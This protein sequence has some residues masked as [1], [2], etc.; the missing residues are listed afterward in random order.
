VPKDDLD[1]AKKCDL[2]PYPI[3]HRTDAY[4]NES[5]KFYIWSGGAARKKYENLADYLVD[6]EIDR[7]T[8][9]ARLEDKGCDYEEIVEQVDQHSW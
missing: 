5:V 9:M 1:H 7:L 2:N 4:S 8:E 6:H 3:L